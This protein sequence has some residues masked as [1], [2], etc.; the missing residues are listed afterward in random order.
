MDG[1]IA[2]LESFEVPDPGDLE[3]L[4]RDLSRNWAVAEVSDT[5][6]V[7]TVNI[8]LSGIAELDLS[9]APA[10]KVTNIRV[11]VKPGS[12]TLT[13][14]NLGSTSVVELTVAELPSNQSI[15]VL[16]LKDCRGQVRVA[17]MIR[18]VRLVC[19]HPTQD[20]VVEEI[21][22]PDDRSIVVQRDVQ[23]TVG[24]PLTETVLVLD[25][26]TVYVD[27]TIARV[28]MGQ[29]GSLD[30]SSDGGGFVDEMLIYRDTELTVGP[31]LLLIRTI[32]GRP[33][34]RSNS[35]ADSLGGTETEEP[36]PVVALQVR[37]L[38]GEIAGPALSVDEI[39]NVAV[40]QKSRTV[41][42]NRVKT[43]TESEVRGNVLLNLREHATVAQTRFIS[44]PETDPSIA[45]TISSATGSFLL[46]VSGSARLGPAPGIHIAAGPGGLA[47]TVSPEIETETDPWPGAIMTGVVLPRGLLGRRILDQLD[48][49]YQFT[50]FVADLPGRDQD[51]RAWVTRRRRKK[52]GTDAASQRRLFEDAEF[53]RE[54]AA[55]CRRK[56]TPGSVST[57]VAWC[58]YRLRNMKARGV[59]RVALNA[60]RLLGYGERPV[61]ALLLWVLL[62][63]GLAGPVLI[64]QGGHPAWCCYDRLFV[65]AGRLALGPL[66][67]LLKGGALT[68]GDVAEI[69]ARAV[70]S[71]PLVTGALAVRNYVKSE[72]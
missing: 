69:A 66:A 31:D 43:V 32:R 46:D 57:S 3:D 50:P 40:T 8:S 41:T 68:G 36:L 72:R 33:L 65:E 16:H 5:D 59:E 51:V 4:L 45:P 55:L 60:Y 25:G 44:I 47:I 56:G 24:E 20:E 17:S 26:G 13:L 7:I 19:S 6:G 42:L 71:I 12:A 54:L 67:G 35:V 38:P 39:K 62:S 11:Q 18:G 29:S 70:T 34:E 49:T 30:K 27:A 22:D 48:G 1:A 63:V 52:Y 28:L 53:M 21:A 2:D 14:A 61:P 10:R 15:D 9:K 37:P 64:A 23:L 58:A